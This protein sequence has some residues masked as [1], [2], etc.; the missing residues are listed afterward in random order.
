[1]ESVRFCAFEDPVA[2][3][4][5]KS[6]QHRIRACPCKSVQGS[7]RANLCNETAAIETRPHNAPLCGP[8]RRP[9]LQA[10]LVNNLISSDRSDYDVNHIRFAPLWASLGP[11]WAPLGPLWAPLAPLEARV[12]GPLIGGLNSSP[13]PC[14][15][16]IYLYIYV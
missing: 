9:L 5:W 13:K 14:R 7:I 4:P 6:V 11:S 2:C 8:C 3:S 1:M 16:H 10:R 12:P 15:K